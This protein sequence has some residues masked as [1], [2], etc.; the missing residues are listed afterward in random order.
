MSKA[1]KTDE[2]HEEEEEET[3]LVRCPHGR[4]KTKSDWSI[5]Y[6]KYQRINI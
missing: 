5:F 1:V 2:P 3:K 6:T 4:S